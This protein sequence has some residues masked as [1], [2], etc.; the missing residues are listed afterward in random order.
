[1]HY[2]RLSLSIAEEVG[3][4]FFEGQAYFQ[5]GGC[6]LDLGCWNEALFHF[7]TSVEILDAIRASCISEDALKISFRNLFKCAY[8]CL[9]QVLIMLQ[10]TDEAL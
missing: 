3:S 10:L 8:T 6:L 2:L 4:K 1:M 9:W 7:L 5:L